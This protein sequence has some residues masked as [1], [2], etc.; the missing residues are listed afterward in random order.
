MKII[1]LKQRLAALPP[2]P[3]ESEPT[4]HED[5]E[6]LEEDLTDAINLLEDC[7]KFFEILQIGMKMSKNARVE[8]EDLCAE[9]HAYLSQYAPDEELVEGETVDEIVA[10]E[11]CG[12]E[13]K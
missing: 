5:G 8:I 7:G 13:V 3:V 6:A 10:C 11:T 2:K 9:I 1:E 4:E 12:Q